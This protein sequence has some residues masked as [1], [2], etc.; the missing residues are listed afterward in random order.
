[1]VALVVVVATVAAAV[2]AM[3]PMVPEARPTP[4]SCGKIVC[5]ESGSPAVRSVAIIQLISRM[6]FCWLPGKVP[7]VIGLVVGLVGPV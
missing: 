7:G 5:H 1:M 3:V 2:A 4:W 6:A